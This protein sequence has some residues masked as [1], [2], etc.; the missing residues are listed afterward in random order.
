MCS[1]TEHFDHDQSVNRGF[2]GDNI[3]GQ[4]LE[5]RKE[6]FIMRLPAWYLVFL[7]ITLLVVVRTSYG[8]VEKKPFTF[9]TGFKSPYS[10]IV[11]ARMKEVFKRIGFEV[12][13]KSIPSQRALVLANTEGDGDAARVKNIKQL[14]PKE[15]NNLLQISEEIILASLSVFTKDLKFYVKGWN[16]LKPYRNGARRGNKFAEKNLTGDRT[17][18][19][20]NT[21][22]FKMLHAGRFD[23]A[24]EWHLAGIKT[25]NSLNLSG[26][27]PRKPP[28]AFKKFYI[29][30]HK[31][32]ISLIPSI[33][34][35]LKEMRQDGTYQKLREQVLAQWQSKK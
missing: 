33:C 22:L 16:S 4:T 6:G 8:D 21:Q 31:R 27:K 5:Q 17:F 12:E 7:L 25:I 26:I 13:I 24:V 14:A 35:T 20:T 1:A 2:Q 19:P 18:V 34:A 15:T 30:I 10:D 11:Q 29:L 32:H 9:Y 23:T 3:N 28:V